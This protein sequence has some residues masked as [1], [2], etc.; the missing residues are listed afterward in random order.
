M[1]LHFFM[2]FLLLALALVS[3]CALADTDTVQYNDTLYVF[4]QE[5]AP[6][7]ATLTLQVAGE[8]FDPDTFAPVRQSHL[9]GAVFGLYTK[10]A[11]DEY[12]PFPNPENPA[13]ALTLTSA[14][15]DIVI[16]LPTSVDLYL[17]QESAPEGYGIDAEAETYRALSLPQTLLY[18]NRQLDMQGIWLTLTGVGGPQPETPLAGVAFSLD[19]MG[20]THTLTTGENGT[21]TLTG[22]EPGEYTLIQQTAVEG[23][24]IDQPRQTLNIAPNE[25]L[26][27]T[28][29][30]SR[31]GTL[32]LQTLGIAPDSSRTP[33][34]IPV[35]RA[36]E[37]FDSEGS[38]L[39]VLSTGQS[40]EL[41]ASA[42]G[43]AYSLRAASAAET[44]DGYAVDTETHEVLLYSGQASTVQIAVQS[45]MGFF[46]LTHVSASDGQAV[47]GGVFAL[48]DE[49]GASVLIFDANEQGAYA[50]LSPLPAGV[51]TLRMERAADGY[52]F[53]DQSHSLTI[54][55]FLDEASATAAVAFT[56]TPLP[57]ALVS[58]Q[59]TA[60]VQSCASLFD[61]DA[62]IS[63]VL[64]AF[65]GE[66]P[67][68][69]T[70]FAFQY[71]LP[72]LEGLTVE[73]SQEN[74]AT[75]HI[76]RRLPLEGVSEVSSLVVAGTVSYAFEYP[77]DAAGAVNSISVSAPFDVQI[78]TFAPRAS[79]A[80]FA[81]S[82]HV[83]DMEGAPV[84][85]LRVTLGEQEIHTDPFGAYAFAQTH[86][87]AQPVFYPEAGFGVKMLGQDAHVLP[88]RTLTGQIVVHGNLEG[89]PVSL[90]IGEADLAQPEADG[91]F[92][93]TGIFAADDP[94]TADTPA[95]VLSR[96]EQSEDYATVHLYAAASLQGSA[97]DPSGAAVAG[98]RVSLS[99]NGVF[100]GVET[101]AQ[102]HYT[103]ENLFPGS[104]TLT[105]TPPEGHVLNSAQTMQLSLE[106]GQLYQSEAI[107]TM[108]PATLS[109]TVYDGDTAYAG[110]P[111]VLQPGNLETVTD[112]EGNFAF[113]GLSLGSYR[114]SCEF[115]AETVVIEAPEAIDI[116][117]SAERAAV[118]VRTVRPA[119]LLGQ[120]WHDADDDGLLSASEGGLA[121][122][123]VVLLDDQEQ[124]VATVLTQSNGEFAF[125]GLTPG[126]YQLSVTLPSGM[127]F[128]RE[129]SGAVRAI[130]GVDSSS[131]VSGWYQLASGE[132][133]SGII[134]GGTAAN[135]IHGMLWEDLNG[136]GILDPG[137]PSIAN[138]TVSLLRGE[139]TVQTVQTDAGGAYLFPTLRNG[140]YVLR[141]AL[142]EGYMFTQPAMEGEGLTVST[143]PAA[144]SAEA[145]Y[146]VEL[147]RW[148]SAPQINA[149]VLRKA[150]LRAHVWFDTAA[151][152][153][154]PG[155][156]P[157]ANLPVSL[158][159]I[160]GASRSLLSQVVTDSAGNVAFEGLRPGSYQ[161]EYH[162]PDAVQ[163]G[164][165]GGTAQE[166]GATG[167]SQVI[168]LLSGDE[169]AFDDVSITQLGSITGIVFEDSDYNGLREEHEKGIAADIMLLD[170]NGAVVA[171]A[172]SGA[173]GRY[174]FTQVKAGMYTI[175]FTLPDG[176][177]FTK[178][179]ADAPSYN[180]DVPQ[181]DG[182]S[183]QTDAVYLPM[184]ETLLLDAGAYRPASISGSVWMDTQNNGQYLSS[185][186]NP[187]MP[188]CEVALLR[189]DAT[190]ILRTTTDE[191]GA[192]LFG[193]LEP[194]GYS[195]RFFLADD[196]FFSYPAAGYH[197]SQVLL[198]ESTEGGT[199][200]IVL[201]SGAQVTDVDAGVVQAGA[202]RGRVASIKDGSGLSGVRVAL[203]RDSVLLAETVTAED[204]TYHIGS[205]RPGS[206][207]L[208]FDCPE[209]WTLPSGESTTHSIH[210]PQAEAS[211]VD[212][213][214]LPEATIE[215]AVWLEEAH[216][217]VLSAGDLPL[218]DLSVELYLVTGEESS[219]LLHTVTTDA[220]GGY[221][222]EKLLP[223]DYSVLF[224][225][226]EDVILYDE[227]GIPPF[228]LEMG[229]TRHDDV[230]AFRAARVSGSVWEDLDGNGLWDDDEPP[231]AAV[232]VA[233]VH[234]DGRLLMKTETDELG[235]Y[236][237]EGIPPVPCSVRFTLPS[238]YLFSAPAENGS[239]PA[240][241]DDFNA[242]TDVYHLEMGQ[243]LNGI[244][245]GA[246]QRVR[247]GDL[248][249]LD[250]NGNGLQETSEPGIEGVT[251]SLWA[252]GSDARDAALVMETAT[253]ANGRYRFDAL[254]PGAFY[255]VFTI[256]EGHLPTQ[257]I[258]SL[259]QINSKLPW[260]NKT[261]L[262]TEPF[263]A[264]SGQHILYIDAGLVS[265]ETAD[266]LGW[267]VQKD[268]SIGPGE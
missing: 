18:T 202:V 110:I 158:Y 164:F 132:K 190:E 35:N 19:G 249:W 224:L 178:H 120:V 59:V 61:E 42:E 123:E 49:A 179:R 242:S 236:Q 170:G 57:A 146:A 78:A 264:L 29:H 3:G 5:G 191:A 250:E 157:H 160:S 56:S 129:A 134:C 79:S 171:Q 83:Y 45:T 245:A 213:H 237:F 104:Y 183:S 136:N 200:A 68:P 259:P 209:G 150:S 46:T 206:G 4:P 163:W 102:G 229:E 76:A 154:N 64:S 2:V 246:Q 211:T 159:R 187:P 189:E 32:T 131:A 12:V 121:G 87:Q 198:T 247:I 21:A 81:V 216:D 260:Q 204:G 215:G 188:G 255:V 24:G 210:I 233:L 207:T 86:G 193:N 25:P 138:S 20:Q 41:V 173:E 144:D 101:D 98:V 162:L 15:E 55:P 77:I 58:P 36:Y 214:F 194:G 180:S 103:F 93:I 65:D 89:Y 47:A 228:S 133:L 100:E 234:S 225:L 113:D 85:G 135:S 252:A 182:S 172:T 122:A 51:Y 256:P 199:Q 130:V 26:Q 34:L 60:T 267:V 232:S 108:V 9:S 227:D 151:S 126:V 177:R 217:G 169:T 66:P 153:E 69:I 175:R 176:L 231:L 161:L 114:L 268:G 181:V 115:P 156:T 240:L 52:L 141:F 166:D 243:A 197:S 186:S 258:S 22:L 88:L 105:I 48:Y 145:S 73:A 127:I 167:Y 253:D 195:I 13:Q 203:T 92:S 8:S 116:T 37:V 14:H 149:G 254:R 248:V 208:T 23:Y 261:T 251:V 137:E 67:L 72:E 143:L 263:T 142:P 128:S 40:M 70:G 63:F 235:A 90:T 119:S 109:G 205:I 152:G 139:T 82:G 10:N 39:G 30:N 94:L 97:A 91:T 43:T 111:V 124:A 230:P 107:S 192:Y 184:G 96:I 50:P 266:T 17:K 222:F 7:T 185:G 16:S 75:V 95:G 165:T 84:Q 241:T 117:A 221:A 54:E 155:N 196:M 220:N 44:S 219:Q 238:Q 106:A 112:A 212:I 168:S 262:Q 118:T 239:I 28:L 140:D 174:T 6:A 71:T 148:R 27:V 99:G 33:R 53:S 31:N 74:G 226:P 80:D 125:T 62:T 265:E 1:R 201:Q 244:S 38:S 257:P 223:G 147:R 11:R 218:S